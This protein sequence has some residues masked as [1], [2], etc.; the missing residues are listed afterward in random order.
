MS[1][2]P[3]VGD[4]VVR[5]GKP[6]VFGTVTDIHVE[7]VRESLKESQEGQEP[8]SVVITVVWDNGTISHFIPEGLEVVE[9]G[10]HV[11]AVG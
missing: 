3:N 1:E 4:R 7:T 5:K 2:R 8:P 9:Q 6:G 11:S 10:N